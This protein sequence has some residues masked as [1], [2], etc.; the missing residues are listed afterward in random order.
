MFD[1][2]AFK[3]YDPFTDTKLC[4]SESDELYDI[5]GVPADFFDTVRR[6]KLLIRDLKLKDM[7]NELK[8]LRGECERGLHLISKNPSPLYADTD[9]QP[10]G[11]SDTLFHLF[12]FGDSDYSLV[13]RSQ[14]FGLLAAALIGTIY[15]QEW[16]GPDEVKRRKEYQGMLSRMGIGE[17]QYPVQT[18]YIDLMFD[19][20]K[21]VMYGEQFALRA[22]YG[23]DE[24]KYRKPP[25]ADSQC[26][27]IMD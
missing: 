16:P 19:A 5:P 13:E 22:A 3:Y 8:N 20:I 2:I 21:A 12:E 23:K 10:A 9:Y 7:I 17:Y 18:Y 24:T 15:N 25:Q 1:L 27:H 6:C 11:A 26:Q 14:R 4:P